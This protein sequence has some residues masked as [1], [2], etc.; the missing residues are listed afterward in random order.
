MNIPVSHF[1]TWEHFSE[2][3]LPVM[4]AE[5]AAYGLAH[6][7]L[8][9][10]SCARMLEA[11]IFAEFLRRT[12][13][14]AELSV[15]NIHAPHMPGW[16]LNS[17]DGAVLKRHLQLLDLYADFNCDTV[18]FHAGT[19]DSG[20][21]LAVLRER[22]CR[23]LDALIHRADKLGMT[24]VLEN[25]IFPTDVPEELLYYLKR[26]RCGS[27]G[28]CFDA[29]HAN[30]M[31]GRSGKCSAD[32]VEWIF[33]RWNGDVHFEKDTLG[34]LLPDIVTCHL[35][36]NDGYDDQ[37]KLPGDGTIDWPRLLA[38]LEGAPRLRSFQNESEHLKYAIPACRIAECFHKLQKETAVAV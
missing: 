9:S 22:S 14:A 20:E 10:G 33:R 24:V 12:C 34:L 29:G 11:P 18:N 13:R 16:E 19:N 17:A 7:S 28:I 30:L 4:F 32:M 27:F 25:T 35:H 6:I 26:F 3:E 37:H 36:D 15:L 23:S 8:N 38:R 31:D 21:P 5:F 1:H 2:R